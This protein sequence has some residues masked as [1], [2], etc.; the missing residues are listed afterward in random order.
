M[1]I[2]YES[3]ERRPNLYLIESILTECLLLAHNYVL[4]SIHREKN[5]EKG[6]EEKIK[7]HFSKI[8]E[9]YGGAEKVMRSVV[10]YPFSY[11]D[12]YSGRNFDIIL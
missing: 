2:V 12:H 9:Y 3:S 1:Q 5:K 8:P 7:A 6:N 11:R 4:G 10:I